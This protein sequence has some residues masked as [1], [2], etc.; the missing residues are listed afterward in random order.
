[1]RHFLLLPIAALLA[2]A[3][4]ACGGSGATL[5]PTPDSPAALSGDLPA[6]TGESGLPAIPLDTGEAERTAS[7]D[8]NSPPGG[9]PATPQVITV[10]GKDYLA[11][12]GGVVEGDALKL[13]SLPKPED[14]SESYVPAHGLYKVSGLSGKRPLSLNIECLPGT[15]GDAYYV[16]VA[17]YT[18]FH[19]Q[20]FGPVT[21]PEFQLDLRNHKYEFTTHLGN[22]YFIIVVPPA[23]SATHFKTSVIAGPRDP[24]GLPGGPHHLVATDGK[25]AEAVGLSWVPGANAPGYD[26]FRKAARANAQWERIG[27]TTDTKYLDKPL[28]DYKLFFYRV[29][30]AGTAGMSAWSNVDSGFAGGGEDPCVIR[31]DITAPGGT[32]VPGVRV[33]LVGMGEEAMRVTGKDGRFLFADLPR[34]RYIVAPVHP[35]LNFLPPYLKVDLRTDRL[36]EVHFTALRDAPFHRLWGFVF[37]Y[38]KDESGEPQF[39]PMAGV[40]VQANPVGHPDVLFSAV[41]NEDGFYHVEDL[42]LGVYKAQ[43]VFEGYRFLPPFAEVIVN[44]HNRPDR[45]DFVG[46][47]IPPSANDPNQPGGV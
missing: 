15:L 2:I 39:A 37:E 14:P 33:V 42:P 38:A 46:V 18:G 26:V 13:T 20:W 35:A 10:L 9:D 25:L 7:A 19:W 22:M 40:T 27:A 30:A 3:L 36:A 28:P 5:A 24:G 32:A 31:G 8:G 6:T 21:L 29:R 44:G 41:T 45:R 4:A 23:M 1:M 11:M 34:G 16:G 43:A 12:N 17:N 47:P